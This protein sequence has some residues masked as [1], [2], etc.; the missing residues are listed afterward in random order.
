MA[1]SD[2]IGDP[3]SYFKKVV[4]LEHEGHSLRFRVAQD[5]FSS[6]EVDVGTRLLLRTLEQAGHERLRKV[7][8]LG[9]GYGPLGLALK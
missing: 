7:L 4:S 5:L 8:D 3:D 1:R 9:C 6:H 2:G